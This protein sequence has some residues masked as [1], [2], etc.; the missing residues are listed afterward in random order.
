MKLYFYI[1]GLVA[2]MSG[3]IDLDLLDDMLPADAGSVDDHV[4]K[5]DRSA[6]AIEEISIAG[7]ETGVLGGT[8]TFAPISVEPETDS[9]DTD[10]P[11]L[12]GIVCS[13]A[14]RQEGNTCVV[15]GAVSA[16]FRFITD[17]P[18]E[19]SFTAQ[20]EQ[21]GAVLSEPFATEHN[22]LVTGLLTESESTIFIDVVDINGNRQETQ[23]TL[24]TT[25]SPPVLITE[26]LADPLGKEPDQE[27][28]EIV[29]LGSLEIS[30]K[31]WMLDDNGDRNG[32]I[33]SNDT[34]LAP[35][36]V[37]LFVA[38]TYNPN[39]GLDP[40]PDPAAKIIFLETSIGSNGLKNSEAETIEL[41]DANGVLVSSYN[42]EVGS[43][44]EGAS[45]VRWLAELPDGC[46]NAFTL[47]PNESS[48][49]GAI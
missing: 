27:F 33:I 20:T 4:E 15:E 5:E 7:K 36:Q 8:D 13:G 29:N 16:W 23:V 28:V 2:F 25:S 49:P 40:S 32:D 34:L 9:A 45:V 48:S 43:P 24:H 11:S 39:A 37:A 21:T 18:S 30:L 10:P 17:E 6:S 14:E 46:P 1:F 44:K 38:P 42:G 31:G 35:G 47:A 19:I 41:F 3:C 26:V 22:M 12:G